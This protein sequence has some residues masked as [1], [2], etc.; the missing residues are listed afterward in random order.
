MPRRPR[1]GLLFHDLAK[2]GANPR[3]C[4]VTSPTLRTKNRKVA[5]WP[6][7]RIDGLAPRPVPDG[8]RFG[9][10]RRADAGR[11]SPPSA[12]PAASAVYL[13]RAA[14]ASAASASSASRPWHVAPQRGPR[15][16]RRGGCRRRSGAR[17]RAPAN[18]IEAGGSAGGFEAGGGRRAHRARVLAL[19]AARGAPTGLGRGRVGW[20]LVPTP[21]GPRHAAPS[22]TPAPAGGRSVVA[23]ACGRVPPRVAGVDEPRSAR[24]RRHP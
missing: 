20:Q 6:A 16:P 5:K 18:S 11:L 10:A 4:L 15:C 19:R 7:T 3:R 22:M 24:R 8:G 9:R 17:T 21:G 13:R 14:P 1:H 12:A 23:L 2:L